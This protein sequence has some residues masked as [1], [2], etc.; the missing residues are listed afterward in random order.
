MIYPLTSSEK[1]LVKNLYKALNK[2]PNYE[3]KENEMIVRVLEIDDK[4]INN[5][6]SQHI[7]WKSY[8]T[9]SFESY[10]LKEGYNENANVFFYIKG[11]KK[12]KS[13]LEYNSIEKEAEVIYPYGPNLSLESMKR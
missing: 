10:S 6:V 7:I 12:E 1:Q 5:I 2:Q 4:Q 9:K 8:K 3:A 13:L 11:S